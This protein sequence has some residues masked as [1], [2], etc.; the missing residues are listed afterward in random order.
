[1]SIIEVYKSN[2][3]KKQDIVDLR[4]WNLSNTDK[5]ILIKC[6]YFKP[7]SSYHVE[8]FKDNKSLLQ[9]KDETYTGKDKSYIKIEF[10]PEQEKSIQ[11][12]NSKKPFTLVVKENGTNV[13]FEGLFMRRKSQQA[14]AKSSSASSYGYASNLNS[15]AET[16]VS[17][18][19]ASTST[20]FSSSSSNLVSKS[21]IK[22]NSKG[23]SLSS[24]DS[25][26]SPKH[27]NKTFSELKIDSNEQNFYSFLL[28]VSDWFIKDEKYTKLSENIYLAADQKAFISNHAIRNCQAKYVGSFRIEVR[29]E[30]KTRSGNVKL[31]FSKELSDLLIKGMPVSINGN[32]VEFVYL[33]HSNSGMKDKNFWAIDRESLEKMSF[34]TF[35]DKLGNFKEI[36]TN[37]K[38]FKRFSQAFST[39]TPTITI[40]NN[41]Y[42]CVDDDKCFF[43]KEEYEYTD[44]IG[45]IRKQVAERISAK[46][47]LEEG[48]KANIFQIR[49]GGFKGVLATMPDNVF[50][51]VL[52]KHKVKNKSEIEVIFRKSQKKFGVNANSLDLNVVS[53]VGDNLTPASLNIEFLII[54]DGLVH[55]RRNSQ[56][57]DRIVS[58]YEEYLNDIEESISDPRK[59]FAKLFNNMEL[60]E[61]TL[62]Y[63]SI[64]LACANDLKS[65]VQKEH[66]NIVRNMIIEQTLFNTITKNKFS[67]KIEDS[68]YFMGVLDESETLDENEVYVSFK[69]QNGTVQYLNNVWV[70]IG[71]TPAYYLS[72]LR[73][74]RARYVPSLRHLVNCVAFSKKDKRPLPNVLSGGDLDGDLYFVTW[75]N[76]FN[77]I[78]NK[79]PIDYPK[80]DAKNENLDLENLRETIAEYFSK[81]CVCQDGI[82]LWHYKL[83]CLYDKG[84]ERMET[85]EYKQ[86]VLSINKCI[87]GI[88]CEMDA[89]FSARPKWYFSNGD[90]KDLPSDSTKNERIEY[91]YDKIIK[92]KTK[93]EFLDSMSRPDQEAFKK[94]SLV[95]QLVY[96]TLK[97]YIQLIEN[98]LDKSPS[99]VFLTSD[100]INLLKKHK[101]I[102]PS[103]AYDTDAI[104]CIKK[105]FGSYLG[106]LD[107]AKLKGM[108]VKRQKSELDH[109]VGMVEKNMIKKATKKYEKEQAKLTIELKSRIL[110][111]PVSDQDMLDKLYENCNDLVRSMLDAD[112]GVLVQSKI[113]QLYLALRN[114]PKY[115]DIPWLFY[116]VLSTLKNFINLKK[117][118][119]SSILYC[120]QPYTIPIDLVKAFSSAKIIKLTE[121]SDE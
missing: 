61:F 121:T 36:K 27:P 33:G 117:N 20:D 83:V 9:F 102:D 92:D 73:K 80:S 95:S 69:D 103:I 100:D 21:S 105:E 30:S 94:S 14:G 65:S 66:Y 106:R 3:V 32:K 98:D 116:D 108:P 38:L 24:S 44:G 96:L 7:G 47:K 99:G 86:L 13:A 28:V 34:N 40:T 97:K 16:V 58:L 23:S 48:F 74:V 4:R 10:S 76:M 55:N 39:S 43:N 90:L 31:D 41:T 53:W 85:N 59:A 54:L 112:N 88:I 45:L 75:D 91:L 18:S 107:Q 8:F 29:T 79:E 35:L 1:M 101:Q 12:G 84:R 93:K 56:L 11:S 110:Q 49:C 57:K 51:S 70:M 113:V 22:S 62:K 111:V 64:L 81:M 115:Y 82:G 2:D 19:D 104:E 42:V 17:G 120:T 26:T 6:E 118:P 37:E 114:D 78:E 67:I 119:S 52:D 50:D 5:S 25:D 71:R 87:D 46:L 68:R 77:E 15:E 60:N 109:F 72:E 89:K 63:S